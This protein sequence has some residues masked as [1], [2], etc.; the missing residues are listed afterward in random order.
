MSSHA[1]HDYGVIYYTCDVLRC[2]AAAHVRPA[3]GELWL[4]PVTCLPEGWHRRGDAHVC[5]SHADSRD[6]RVSSLVWKTST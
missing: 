2:V 6:V 1:L 4:D 5:R 3:Q